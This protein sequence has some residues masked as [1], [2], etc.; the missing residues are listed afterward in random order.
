MGEHKSVRKEPSM[1]RI[2]TMRSLRK[3]RG[4]NLVAVLAVAMTTMMFTT[5]FTFAESMGKTMMEMSLH[6]SG[7]LA[8]ATCKEI[9][10]D[11]IEQI[12]AHPDVEKS[13]WSIVVGLAENPGLA[14]RQVEI[15]YGTDQY[16]ED[17]F[18]YPAT[19]RMPEEENE[20]ALDT[21]TLERLGISRELGEQVTLQW[22]KD[23][24]SDEMTESV[25]TLCGFWEGNLS[26]YASMAWVSERFA[27]EACGGDVKE[28]QLCGMRMMGIS[29]GNTDNIEAKTAK[30][31]SDCGLSGLD[32]HTNITYSDEIK[33]SILMENLPMYGGMAL[34]FI[35]GYLIIYNV[36]QISVA[37]DIQF[38]GKLKTLG[39]T[40]K[41][42][43]RMILRQGCLV[44]FAGIP[45]GLLIGYLLGTVLLPVLISRPGMDALVSAN[46]V[47][48]IG[49]SVF[50]FAT[51]LISCLLPAR[52]AG[53]VSPV[54]ALRYTDGEGSLKKKS[55]KRENGASLPGMAWANLWRD[56]KRTLLVIGS[57]TLGMVLM[58]F[59]YAKNASFDIEKYL[60]EL[61][62]ADFQ[63]DDA[64]NEH[65]D[66]YDPAS[67]TI[68]E[69]LVEDILAQEGLESVGRLYCREVQMPVSQ[70]ACENF[71]AFYTEETLEDFASY[72]PTF[73]KWKKKYDEALLGGEA[74]HT[75][76]GADGL[77]LEA[78]A[79]GQYVMA[80]EYDAEKF[81]GGD[82]VLAIGPAA[83]GEEILPTYSVGEKIQIEGRE[84]TVMAVLLP[85]SPLVEG[86]REVFD[87]PLV[88]PADVFTQ[89]WQGSN[90][91]KFYFNIDDSHM[92]EASE[93]LREYQETKATGMN[94]VSRK[95]IE[96]QY[97]TETRSSA[98]IGYAISVVIALVGILNFINSM[99]TAIISRKKEFAM[100]QSV[101]MTKRQLRRMLA[102][103]GLSYAGI[104]LAVSFV[105][106]AVTVGVLVRAIAADGYYTFRF[107]LLPLVGCTPV[108]LILAVLVPYIC[109]RNLEKRSVVERLRMAD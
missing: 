12:A 104:T 42:I 39:M 63:I 85:L 34:V 54:E 55:R 21:L 18:A 27:L 2:L 99:V 100:I 11:Q 90:L 81:A 25:F 64:T 40:K 65:A 51:V 38:Y 75:V 80:G 15:R 79:S 103:E 53:K 102:F 74:V 84:F 47:I 77:I 58:S 41:Q 59:F 46:P 98:V 19:G 24:H 1:E 87:V 105:L 20:I 89:L 93:L 13:G 48:F 101:G 71:R 9:T 45:A 17:D 31:L 49:S 56:R 37:S 8:H 76:Y 107:T 5:L 30:V 78:A 97:Q 50:A 60:I 61:S 3:N 52:V 67:R 108:L 22:R 88:I 69:S 35:A 68:D 4:R 29:F 32:F 86:A 10:D 33:K 83:E 7:T 43:R 72:D 28:G 95:E 26:V 23:I 73:K 66:G 82:Y 109:F 44:A 94:I 106:G 70:Q 91:R 36:F 14:G 16:A 57:L 92:E 96:A 6:Q 62:A